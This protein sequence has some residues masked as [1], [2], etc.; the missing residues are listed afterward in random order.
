[1]GS[2]H[3]KLGE[4]SL[5]IV[6]ITY[7]GHLSSPMHTVYKYSLLNSS[8]LTFYQPMHHQSLLVHHKPQR[9]DAWQ[10]VHSLKAHSTQSMWTHF[11][12]F[13]SCVAELVTSTA[14]LSLHNDQY[15]LQYNDRLMVCTDTTN[16]VL[17]MSRGQSSVKY[18]SQPYYHHR[19]LICHFLLMHS[20]VNWCP[21]LALCMYMHNFNL[22]IL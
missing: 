18:F 1:M 3:K 4:A 11:S 2:I 13:G 7:S 10:N 17:M 16:G 15:R 22:R 6:S 19:W 14:C 5:L 8:L 20:H 9:G 21:S 12:T